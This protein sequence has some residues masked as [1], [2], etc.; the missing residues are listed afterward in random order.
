MAEIETRDIA[1]AGAVIGGAALAAYLLIKGGGIEPLTINKVEF[2]STEPKGTIDI[3]TINFVNNI[4]K[5][6]IS[7]ITTNFASTGA[8]GLIS[9]ITINFNT[10]L[11]MGEISIPGIAFKA[12]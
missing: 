4:P 9:G 1:V 12:S 5:G 2:V 3:N 7:N 8:Q 6:E 10:T 11:P